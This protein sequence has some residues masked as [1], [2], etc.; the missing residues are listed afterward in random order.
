VP[1]VLTPPTREA[2]AGALADAAAAGES[3]RLR[4]GG[5]KLGWGHAVE[6]PSIEL[7][8]EE[9]DE[10]I[11][12]NEGDLTAGFEA[13]VPLARIA[14]ELAD[15]GQRLA[16]DPPLGLAG[17]ERA[18]LGG[19][20]ATADSGPLRHR[21][22]GPRDLVLGMTVA[23]SD[24]TIATSGG[25]V[26]KNVA[27]YDL[28]KLFTG[29]FGTLGA[30]LAANLR[31]HPIPPATA[32]ALAACDDARTLAAGVHALAAA[33]LELE[34][35]DI[36]WRAGR[37]GILAQVAGAQAHRRADRVAR[38]MREAGL[39][40]VDVTDDDGG[41]WARQRAG[42]RSARR[43]LVRIATRPSRI[44]GLLD[45]VDLV[46]GTLVGRGALGI[47]YVELDPEAVRRLLD[48]LPDDAVAVLGDAP[49]ELRAELDPWS[50]PNGPLMDLM[51]R[52]KQRFDPAAVC[53]PGVFAG[54]I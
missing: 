1:S 10:T 41:L 9:L 34:A 8:L 51:R 7:R 26:I 46:A 2:A 19:L 27:G 16:L 3:V 37:G 54:G 43:A 42:Q 13:G 33:P 53:N 39:A 17:A 48:A 52:I 22:G 5:S 29:S 38:V 30:I 11:E 20:L 23:L 21:Y 50:A 18:T 4:G 31:L 36:A 32:T 15:A 35:L 25:K 12:H 6:E 47:S 45:A 24:G 44:P 14:Q 40:H 28:A 49:A